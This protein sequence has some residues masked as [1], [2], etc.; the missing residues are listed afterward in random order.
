[1]DSDDS[2]AAHLSIG[3]IINSQ[4]NHT[5]FFSFFFTSISW[6]TVGMLVISV[7]EKHFRLGLKYLI[8]VKKI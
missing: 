4:Q 5:C 6:I 8:T 2:I 7:A 1:M 3:P